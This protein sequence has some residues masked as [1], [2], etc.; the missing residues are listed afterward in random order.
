MLATM[1]R[2]SAPADL[3]LYLF[4]LPDFDLTNRSL[5]ID[6]L[7]RLAPHFIINCAAYTDV[8]GAER[9]SAQAYAVNGTAVGFLA[10][11][12]A[13]TGAILVHISTDYVFDGC[14]TTPYHEEDAPNPLS[15]Y[16]QSKLLGE[17][18]LVAK[19]LKHYF[20][21]RTGWLYGPG[22][23]NFVESILR[24]STEHEKLRIVADQ[25][26]SPTYTADLVKAIFE[27]L[28]MRD[29]NPGNQSRH[30][31]Y[32]LYHITGEGHCSWYQFA[33]AIVDLARETGLPLKVQEIEAIR[34]EDYPLPAQRPPYSVLSKNKFRQITGHSMPLWQQSLQEYF[35]HRKL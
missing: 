9:N 27:L 21:V 3:D 32:G 15:I 25:I 14:K 1:V 5:V 19:G 30:A 23:G 24:L 16:G 12:A 8:D 34:T 18:E 35:K 10:E 11:A 29:D 33:V 26:G 31:P 4:D 17:Q 13:A 20:L 2:Q 22:G 6:T 28:K 7:V